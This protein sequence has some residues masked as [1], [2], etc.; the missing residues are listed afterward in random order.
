MF[1]EWHIFEKLPQET[2]GG[3]IGQVL[4]FHYILTRKD[5]LL[6]VLCIRVLERFLLEE[7]IS[8]LYQSGSIKR[9]KPYSNLNRVSFISRFSK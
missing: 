4:G 2:R 9:E 5:L 7:R 1:T 8:V 6:S 3:W